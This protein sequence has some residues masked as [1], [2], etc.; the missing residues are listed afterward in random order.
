MARAGATMSSLAPDDLPAVEAMGANVLRLRLPA[1]GDYLLRNPQ[2]PGDSLFALRSRTD[3]QLIGV[4]I[5]VA[6]PA[7]A[8]PRQLDAAMPCFRLGAFGTEGMQ[9]KRV[10]GLFSFLV[11]DDRSGP[12]F[13]LELLAYATMRLYDTDVETLAAQAP[14]DAPHLLRFYSQTF[15]RQGSFPVFEKEL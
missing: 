7:Y 3:G 8:N 11:A 1:L 6:D 5:V 10:N 13:A 2:F 15:Q 4:G 14:S 12:A 9:V